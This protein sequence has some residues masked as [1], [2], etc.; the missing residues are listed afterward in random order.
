MRVLVHL[1]SL[2]LGGS[3]INAVDFARALRDRG[4]DSIL[5]GERDTIGGGPSLLD[6]ADLHGIGITVYDRAAGLLPHARQL[7]R[8]A[9]ELGVDLVHAY[10]MW[11][12]ARNV[13]WGP[14]T[15][16][17]IPWVHTVYEM[18]VSDVVHSHV[19][20]IVGTEYL[21]EDLVDRP[22]PTVLISPPVDLTADS[23][24]VD[25]GAALFRDRY[26]LGDGVVLGIVSR[27]ERQ[28]KATAILVA[29]DAMRDLAST[30]AT[31][32]VVGDGDARSVLRAE[33][34]AVNED[35]GRPAVRMLGALSDPRPAYLA[36]DIM[37]GMG[38]SAA[39]ALAFGKPLIVHGEAGWSRLFEPESARAL[40][41]SSFWSP[42]HPEDPVADLVRIALPL[43][44]D[45]ARRRALGG[46]GR[47]F[48][49]ARFGLD[50]MSDR[51]AGFYADA[52]GAY[53]AR[54]WVLDLPHEWRRL[55]RKVAR[56]IGRMNP[57]YARRGG[58]R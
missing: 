35:V 40:A 24:R 17:R 36:A 46:Y 34:E 18:S 37:I 14:A 49:R 29:I 58:R 55:V 42:E 44:A 1:N 2:E 10:G 13:Y 20:L 57:G 27:L 19:P 3:Q 4:I 32:F 33:A 15:F 16:G 30:G 11:G 5:V 21:V 31:L 7:R 43:I 8:M 45:E 26:R 28:L 39:R 54:E 51:L 47:D 56:R 6:Y 12:A 25:A 9:D 53:G 38:G 23:P 48:A 50:A 41:R 52:I 22:A